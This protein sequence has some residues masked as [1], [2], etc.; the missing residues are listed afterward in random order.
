LLV[1]GHNAKA[2]KMPA[3]LGLRWLLE[4]LRFSFFVEKLRTPQPVS[5]KRMEKASG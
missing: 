4:D 3:S 1:E 2:R 5:I